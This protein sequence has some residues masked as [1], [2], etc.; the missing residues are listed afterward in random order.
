[1]Y[2]ATFYM[3]NSLITLSSQPGATEIGGK[4]DRN[5]VQVFWNLVYPRF[6]V[7]ELAGEY[8]RNNGALSKNL[9]SMP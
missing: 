6:P 7:K 9:N 4:L 1:M 2:T 5:R 8:C 3:F